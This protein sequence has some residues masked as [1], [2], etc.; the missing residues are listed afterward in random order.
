MD[1]DRARQGGRRQE[2]Q[3]QANQRDCQPSD[4]ELAQR[5]QHEENEL[6]RE[7]EASTGGIMVNPP[8]QRH[9]SPPQFFE[10]PGQRS[11]LKH[12]NLPLHSGPN[13]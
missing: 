8:T 11:T 10:P 4:L 13:L 12:S 9:R 7:F 2:V 3:R 6:Q 5:W 1:G